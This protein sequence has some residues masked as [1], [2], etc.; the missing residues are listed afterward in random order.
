MIYQPPYN[1]QEQHIIHE[2]TLTM[3]FF[4][5]SKNNF[6]VASEN[7]LKS[8]IPPPLSSGPGKKHFYS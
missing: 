8:V 4:P 2:E 3:F 5:L 6:D 7:D 1:N